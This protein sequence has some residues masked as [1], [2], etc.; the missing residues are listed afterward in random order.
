MAPSNWLAVLEWKRIARSIR[1]RLEWAALA[2]VLATCLVSCATNPPRPKVQLAPNLYANSQSFDGVT[3]AVV[4]FDG[5]RGLYDNPKDP[6]PA[7][8]DFDWLKAGVLPT[9]IIMTNESQRAV[10]LDPSQITCVDAKLVSYQT[11]TSAEAGQAVASSEAFRA[12]VRGGL[13]GGLLGGAI[14]AGLGA[15]LG[16]IGGGGWIAQ[17]AAIGGAI[18]GAQGIFSG[19]AANRA[20]LERRVSYLLYSQQFKEKVLSPG[21]TQDG[22]VYFPNVPLRAVRLVLTDSTRESGRTV[23][24]MVVT[25]PAPMKLSR[26]ANQPQDTPLLP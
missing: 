7:H 6:K 11:Y 21:M 25:P 15:A 20:E 18:G 10:I 13:G 2:M 4:P 8:P 19:A 1:L 3:I 26:A 23:E 24:I 22:V 5:Q 17:G 12:Y 16:A 9:R 14:G